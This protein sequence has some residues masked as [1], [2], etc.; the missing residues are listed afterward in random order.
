MIAILHSSSEVVDYLINDCKADINYLNDNGD[1]LFHYLSDRGTT[2]D[3]YDIF[4]FDFF[5]KLTCSNYTPHKC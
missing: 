1:N 4:K 3:T 2:K 5:N